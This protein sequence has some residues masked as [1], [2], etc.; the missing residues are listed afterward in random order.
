M[1]EI[2]SILHILELLVLTTSG[3]LFCQLVF[4]P[5]GHILSNRLFTRLSTT[6][7]LLA[8]Y[9]ISI[10]IYA[11]LLC[12]GIALGISNTWLRYGFLIS[13]SVF[14]TVW[15]LSR[16]YKVFCNDKQVSWMF[17]VWFIYFLLAVFITA[18]PYGNFHN[19]TGGAAMKLSGLPIDNLIPYN[20]SRYLVERINPRKLEVVP[21]WGATDRGPLGAI[22]TALGFIILGQKESKHWLTPS[23]QLYF[24]A[25]LIGTFLNS[26]SLLA[27]WTVTRE[28]FGNRTAK[29]AVMLCSINYFFFLN[30]FFFWPKFLMAYF[31]V[32][33]ALI[34]KLSNYRFFAGIFLA[35]AMLSHDSAL[36]CII[37]LF[38]FLGIKNIRFKNLLSSTLDSIKELIPVI[39]GFIML[40]SP[41]LIYK[42]FYV[43]PSS[44]LLYM[45]LFCQ[46]QDSSAKLPFNKIFTEYMSQN[47]L[48]Q[49]IE[50]RLYNIIHP[51]NLFDYYQSKWYEHIYSQASLIAHLN[52]PVFF[53]ITWGVGFPAF[54]LFLYGLFKIRK[55]SQLSTLSYLLAASF[56]SVV[57]LGL[58]SGCMGNTVSHIWAYPAMLLVWMIA[59]VIVESG[60]FLPSLFLVL[61]L[62]SN[63]AMLIIYLFY[64]SSLQPFLHASSYYLYTLAF[65]FF[66]LMAILFFNTLSHSE[67]GYEE[68]S[69]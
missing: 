12:L 28:L 48:A 24:I 7:K 1:E 18:F 16:Q 38:I 32:L 29:Y 63:I 43:P 3:F 64:Y 8:S 50:T 34:W 42:N 21:N 27:I 13:L 59:A 15:L 19:M 54:L 26:L 14:F 46:I 52:M 58:L 47:T 53:Q 31:L 11:L 37:A 30:I 49:I 33:A 5:I 2:D 4:L 66:S 22:A 65:L 69:K 55:S 67:N 36:F 57:I 45:H 56:G 60:G 51:F 20:F 40:I 62:S 17:L 41:W 44:R 25:Q 68:F 9:S 61:N 10:I 39:F 23:P 6:M 35:A